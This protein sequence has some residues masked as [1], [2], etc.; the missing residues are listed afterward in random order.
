MDPE[1]FGPEVDR[2]RLRRDRIIFEEIQIFRFKPI[3]LHGALYY[4][5]T[6]RRD[7]CHGMNV[8]ALK[9][10]SPEVHFRRCLTSVPHDRDCREG[11]N[12]SPSRP[13]SHAN[14]RRRRTEVHARKCVRSAVHRMAHGAAVPF[15]R[16]CRRVDQH[17]KTTPACTAGRQVARKRSRGISRSLKGKPRHMPGARHHFG[18][19]PSE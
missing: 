14:P 3:A 9:L 8:F 6:F 16:I 19:T 17:E 12:V 1:K 10:I 11:R 7:P 18:K 5:I 13:R 2:A 4:P 15:Q